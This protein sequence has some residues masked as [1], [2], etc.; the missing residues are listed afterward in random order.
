MARGIW[1]INDANQNKLGDNS[2]VKIDRD[3]LN[4]WDFFLLVFLSYVLPEQRIYCLSTR[5]T[6]VILV[7]I[8]V[9]TLLL[10]SNIC[11]FLET[12]V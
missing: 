7:R 2:L 11:S 1:A 8:T 6:A 12:V 3:N 10:L 4:K 9:N 5:G